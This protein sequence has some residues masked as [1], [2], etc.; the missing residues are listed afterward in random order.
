MPDPV[1]TAPEE[2]VLRKSTDTLSAEPV[3]KSSRAALG[4]MERVSTLWNDLSHLLHDQFELVALETQRAALS[5]VA[6]L[7]WGLVVGLLLV[8][9]WLGIMAAIVLFLIALGLAASLAILLVV[10]LNLVGAGISALVIRK[11]SKYLLYPAT[12]R[13]LKS[14]TSSR[15]EES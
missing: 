2:G 4:T 14:Q 3:R 10:V 12:V 15:R 13:S 6:M 7:V 5:L 8:T 11:K 1:R 9:A